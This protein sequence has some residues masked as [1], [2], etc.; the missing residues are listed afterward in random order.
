MLCGLN[1][2][3]TA[4]FP[5]TGYFWRRPQVV[6]ASTSG[7][8]GVGGSGVWEPKLGGL[9]HFLFRAEQDWDA[10]FRHPLWLA[11]LVGGIELFLVV[12]M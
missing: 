9:D 2:Q 11:A 7:C 8:F 3:S 1:S 6:L 12:A 4:V 10:I 5:Q